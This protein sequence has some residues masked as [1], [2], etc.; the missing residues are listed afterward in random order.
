MQDGRPLYDGPPLT[1]KDMECLS[2]LTKLQPRIECNTWTELHDD[3]FVA[4]LPPRLGHLSLTLM[5][6]PHTII[7]LWPRSRQQRSIDYLNIYVMNDFGH[8]IDMLSRFNPE[9][10]DLHCKIPSKGKSPEDGMLFDMDQLS[11]LTFFNGGLADC[12]CFLSNIQAPALEAVTFR[13]T[14]KWERMTARKD[15]PD[16]IGAKQAIQAIRSLEI[17]EWSTRSQLSDLPVD[18]PIEEFTSLET[19]V[20]NMAGITAWNTVEP[21]RILA[22]LREGSLCPHLTRLT[23]GI[24]PSYDTRMCGTGWTKQESAI[25]TILLE[26]EVLRGGV[27]DTKFVV[28]RR[29]LL[30]DMD[31]PI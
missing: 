11:S 31:R 12:C 18:F 9:R 19:L 22:K 14:N 23:I 30:N 3:C 16:F 25:R 15:S 7:P 13:N 1:V 20:M 26:L 8:G 21:L 27:L 28:E 10:L 2:S 6:R 4:L 17:Q 5:D 24:K 29:K